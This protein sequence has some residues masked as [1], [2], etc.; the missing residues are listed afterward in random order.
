MMCFLICLCN[1]T[2]GPV[3]HVLS[4]WHLR[5]FQKSCLKP[6]T[7]YGRFAPATVKGA[8]RSAGDF[9]NS[10]FTG[11][12]IPWKTKYPFVPHFQTSVF[13]F[14]CIFPFSGPLEFKASGFRSYLVISADLTIARTFRIKQKKQ[15][16]K[17]L[18]NITSVLNFRVYK[19]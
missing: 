19:G 14:E 15:L 2:T 6:Y 12:Q 1:K 17:C 5:S 13:P 7:D 11:R 16:E 8:W 3:L 10:L 18:Q 4:S 9:F